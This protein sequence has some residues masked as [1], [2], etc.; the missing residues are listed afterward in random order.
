M[1]GKN[2][3]SLALLVLFNLTTFSMITSIKNNFGAEEI[4]LKDYQSANLTILNG[5][6]TI[7][8][9]N[10]DY[11][12]AETLEIIFPAFIMKKSAETAVYLTASTS[13]VSY[14]TVLRS[15][16]KEGN[17]LCIEKLSH[18]D[19]CGE[20][21]ITIASAYMTLGQRATLN[22][23]GAVS[24]SLQDAP[25]TVN[26]ERRMAVVKD[27]WCFL[28]IT[29]TKFY[30]SQDDT[31]FSFKI[32]GLPE[33]INITFPLILHKGLVDTNGHPMAHCTLNG[34]SFTCHGLPDACNNSNEGHFIH[35]FIVRD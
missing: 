23:D 15:W 4:T 2:S 20:V 14:G 12:S 31:P 11:L 19:H 10:P 21:T 25:A 22:K 8:T 28:L 26:T 6:I 32:D 33:N 27:K 30:Y 3:T 17:T 9:T 16:M 34:S 7:D 29:F 35:L 18:W 24:I 13:P 5:Q 1:E